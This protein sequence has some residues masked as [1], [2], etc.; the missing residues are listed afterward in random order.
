[1]KF[2]NAYKGVKKIWL[3]ELL[4]LLV[5]VLSIVMIIVVGRNSLIV[6]NEFI[7]MREGT[8]G[9]AAGLGIAA[10]I[11]ALIAF[12][13]NLFG[14]I[15]AR[16]DDDN[17]TAALFATLIGIITTAVSSIWNTNL[18]LANW[19]DTITSICSLF[20]SYFVLTGIASLADKCLDN[21]TKEIALKSRTLLE[22]TFCVSVIV[23]FIRNI[24]NIQ[25]GTVL[26]IMGIGALVM[27]LI[28]FVLYMRA[29]SRGKTML[30]R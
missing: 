19:M 16:K 22:A 20:A 4:M 5:T 7:A 13:L 26:L 28:S 12:L 17:F 1:M 3:A 27:E 14:V 23:K 21:E 2:P 11:I 10:G 8:A 29:L 18:R 24:F 30:A 25:N 15:G 6:D 9:V